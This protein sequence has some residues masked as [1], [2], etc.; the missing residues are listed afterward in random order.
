MAKDLL[1][2]KI[3]GFDF[4]EG[5]DVKTV[6]VFNDVNGLTFSSTKAAKEIT[7]NFFNT[8]AE[9]IFG[10]TSNT[11]TSKIQYKDFDINIK[12]NYAGLVE[13]TGVNYDVDFDIKT[14]TLSYVYDKEDIIEAVNSTIAEG[15]GNSI[16]G[17]KTYIE[18]GYAGK[19][20]DKVIGKTIF[21]KNGTTTSLI[22]SD[23]VE[24]NEY[25][26]YLTKKIN[27]CCKYNILFQCEE[28]PTVGVDVFNNLSNEDLNDIVTGVGEEVH[29]FADDYEEET[30]AEQLIVTKELE[31]YYEG[32]F[33]KLVY[34]LELGADEIK[35][36][37]AELLDE[38]LANI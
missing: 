9:E 24:F 17:L 32:I 23:D 14:M 3:V 13:T 38:A 20:I 28:K 8:Y 6:E 25:E 29:T 16:K 5:K 30:V 2:S 19:Y 1:H 12:N 36:H 4:I 31:D 10:V 27:A 35:A 26:L 33:N 37:N 34:S 11:V 15:K 18:Y 22:L 7:K 21:L